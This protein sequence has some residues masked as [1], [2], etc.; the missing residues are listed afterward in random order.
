MMIDGLINKLHLVLGWFA[1]ESVASGMNISTS[2]SKAIVQRLQ[3]TE[4]LLP[5][6]EEV[7]CIWVLFT[8]ERKVE[9]EIDR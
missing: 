1:V 6:V 4:I 7:K 5:N 3:Y 9:Q 2:N 8:S